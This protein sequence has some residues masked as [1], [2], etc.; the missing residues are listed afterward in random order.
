MKK[1]FIFLA[2]TALFGAGCAKNSPVIEKQT[3]PVPDSTQA[4]QVTSPHPYQAITSPLTITGQARGIWFFEAIFPVILTDWDGKII[5]QGTATAQ[6]DW[7]TEQYVPFTATLTFVKPAYKDNG[8][9]ILKKDNPSGLPQ[10]DAA[11]EIPVV[12]K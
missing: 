11:Y 7:M 9:L 6:G 12:F 1:I 2:V 8:T 10:N 3:P 5:A 4:V